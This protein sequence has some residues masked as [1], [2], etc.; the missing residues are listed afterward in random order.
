[1]EQVQIDFEVWM[2]D[3]CGRDLQELTVDSDTGDYDDVDVH[4]QFM[5][6]QA[7]WNRRAPIELPEADSSDVISDAEIAESFNGTNFGTNA[8]RELL[9]V[10]ILKKACG[11]HCGHTITMIMLEMGLISADG[12][13]LKRGQKLM[14]KAYH[15]VMIGGA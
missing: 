9:H 6:Y 11:Y 8:H 10:A 4:N 15:N 12:K 1:M 13:V 7:A 5:A 14:R 2:L 3:F